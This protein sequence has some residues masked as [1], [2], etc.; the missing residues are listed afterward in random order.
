VRATP[1]LAAPRSS[2]TH[3]PRFVLRS[4]DFGISLFATKETESVTRGT[5][6]YSAFGVEGPLGACADPPSLLSLNSASSLPVPP[7]EVAPE[8]AR[9]QRIDNL[10]ALDVYGLG[11]IVHDLA[12][13]HTGVSGAETAAVAAKLA[14]APSP[15]ASESRLA[16]N[17]A[18]ARAMRGFEP[19]LGGRLPPELSALLAS[20]LAVDAAARPSAH[21]ARAAIAGLAAA[22]LTWP[23][24]GHFDQGTVPGGA[25]VATPITE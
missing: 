9:N 1:A 7:R 15:S 17:P 6:R 11:C 21:D 8:V 5:L 18:F 10:P 4:C 19:S 20:L 14:G 24:D 13:A 3:T 2:L 22:S 25:A 16:P 12:H 23:L